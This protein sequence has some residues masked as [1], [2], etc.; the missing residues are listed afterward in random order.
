M[1]V[2]VLALVAA[3]MSA[4]PV[5]VGV[6]RQ[7]IAASCGASP[8][9]DIDWQSFDNDDNAMGALSFSRLEFLSAAFAEVCKD[10]SL[11][12]EVARQIAKVVLSQAHGA[13][14]PVIYLTQ[15]ALHVE[16][17]W[18]KGEPAPDVAFVA[19]EIASR[20]KG[21]EAEAP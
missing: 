9:I 16:Y 2:L 12:P 21:E 1:N 19:A 5:D 10:A 8:E 4:A 20:L 3:F 7:Q 13:A 17:F 11:K 6:I 15:K 18:V 14:D